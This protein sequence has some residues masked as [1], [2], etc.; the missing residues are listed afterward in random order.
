[1]SN[2]EPRV[3]EKYL[4][5]ALRYFF[6]GH[7]LF[8][9]LNHFFLFIPDVVPKGTDLGARFMQVL[10]A[11]HL[12][13]GAK[14]I[15]VLAGLSIMTGLFMPIGLMIEMPVSVVILVVSVYLAPTPRSLYTGPR[16]VIL[17]LFLLSLYW[18]YFKPFFCRPRLAL[19]PLWHD[20]F[21]KD[22]EAA[23]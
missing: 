22:Q 6:G 2:Y 23:L 7:T 12:Y 1:V 10:F 4:V 8:S 15:E 13:D 17:N 14:V 18:G 11:T 5:L 19:K 20:A 3:L 21:S 16:E 9:G